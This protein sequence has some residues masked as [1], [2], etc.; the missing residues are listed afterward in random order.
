MWR[1]SDEFSRI[2]GMT[3]GDEGRMVH[4]AP[5]G[6]EQKELNSVKEMGAK[7]MIHS[8]AGAATATGASMGSHPAPRAGRFHY[9]QPFGWNTRDAEVARRARD[10]LKEAGAA[11]PKE[12]KAPYV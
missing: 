5:S 3:P 10:I 9:D 1:V 8:T 4:S 12:L 2:M 11:D 6:C 7:A